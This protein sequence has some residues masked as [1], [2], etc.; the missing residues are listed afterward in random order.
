MNIYANVIFDGFLKLTR[1]DELIV[2]LQK[3]LLSHNY[4]V[5][6]LKKTRS[7]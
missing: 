4:Y 7:A 5:F 1:N 6:F 2:S 3:S